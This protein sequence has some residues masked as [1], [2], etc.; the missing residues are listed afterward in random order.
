MAREIIKVWRVPEFETV[1]LKRGIEVTHSHP[2]HWHEEFHLCLIQGGT[3]TLLYRGTYHETAASLFFVQPGEVHANF[4]RNPRGCSFVTVNTSPDWLRRAATAIAAPASG[5]PFFQHPL[6]HDRETRRRFQQLHGAFETPAS[7]L[8]RESLLLTFL[9]H[10]LSRYG[11]MRRQEPRIGNE[12]KAVRRAREYLTENFV[13][14]VSL[15]RLAETCQLSPFHLSRVFRETLGMP[16]HA[17]QTQVRLVAAKRL[18][19]QGRTISEAACETG[20]ADQSHFTR[21]CKRVWG[22][23]PGQ[24]LVG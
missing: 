5:T 7:V 12:H 2:K 4:S 10:L 3:G 13:E 11:R 19:A 14:N 22:V 20:F 21:H 16:P 24:L 18:L 8:E 6:A 9:V 17:F 1:E 15:E 23:T